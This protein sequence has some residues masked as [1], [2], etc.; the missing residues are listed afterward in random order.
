MKNNN[1]SFVLML[2]LAITPAMIFAQ[3]S[4]PTIFGDNMV[5]QQGK[6][7]TIWGNAAPSEAVTVKFQKQTKKTKADEKGHW[8]VQ[9]DELTATKQPQQLTVQGKKNKR[10]LSNV[11]I[12][13]V[14]LASGQSNMEYSMSK[15]LKHADTKKGNPEYFYQKY[16]EANSPIIRVLF[17]E[18]FLKA[19]T[20]P[21]KGWQ[22][23]NEKSLAPI[24][25]A[26]YFFA[27]SLME[28]LDVPVGLIS[29]S[30][31][32][33][34]I[35]TWTPEEAYLN[36]PVLR[37]SVSTQ[38]MKSMRMGERFQKM[39][40]PMAPYALKGFLWYQGETNLTNGDREIYAEK[41]KALIESW[42]SAWND[43]NLSF[44]YVQL[45]PHIYSQ[46]RN[47]LESNTWEG[48]PRFWEAQTSCLKIPH[49]G[50]IV[51]TD[52]VD[53]AKDIHPSYKWVV[54]ERLARWALAKD[55]GK[56]DVVYSGP[57][58]KSMWVD[59]NKIIL[60]FDNVGSGLTT[61]DG[62]AP[63]WFYVKNE[64]GR[65]VRTEATID[66]N[67]IILPNDGNKKEPSVRFAWD[68]MAM[69]NLINKEG[70]PA[71]PFRTKT[72]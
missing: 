29:T 65:F 32:G 5:L 51:T 40:K 2:I 22:M 31:G 19:D 67:K 69:P 20:L 68:E 56:T 48:L 36:S 57:T 63:D 14:W 3:V 58:Y 64:T 47:D 61:N 70:L 60:E 9:L 35:E 24:S 37:D 54:G 26:G 10:V 6:K 1:L 27:L 21:S 17:V 16:K 13:E 15:Q 18:K 39:V 50:M 46:R 71:V 25:A 43:N 8:S 38:K 33:T 4:L 7:V 30:W 52:L 62:K 28:N 49:T 42:R 34:P 12:G 66:G 44:Y 45:A 53:D 72:K 11:L 59:G 41:Q 23:L 55:Y